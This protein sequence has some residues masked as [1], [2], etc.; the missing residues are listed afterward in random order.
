MKSRQ[1]HRMVKKSGWLHIR[2]D[3]SHYIYEKNGKTYP[4]PFHG[5]K[6]VGKGLEKKIIK[7]MGL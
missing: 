2:T 6:E 3:G 5:S 1:L 7:E 4:V